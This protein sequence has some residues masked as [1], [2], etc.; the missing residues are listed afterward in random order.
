MRRGKKASGFG[1]GRTGSVLE[2]VGEDAALGP[3][4]P[5]EGAHLPLVGSLE[6]LRV[7]G[8]PLLEEELLLVPSVVVVLQL[9]LGALVE[10][11][12][13]LGLAG[14]QVGSGLVDLP[15]LLLVPGGQFLRVEVADLVLDEVGLD[16]AAWGEGYSF[17]LAMWCSISRR[18]SSW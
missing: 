12:A 15:G 4:L 1:E 17:C 5:L 2:F 7:I 14:A 9:D 3:E 16:E 10:E 11:V 13:V 8:E 18:F 6:L